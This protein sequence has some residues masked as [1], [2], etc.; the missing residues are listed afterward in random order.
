MFTLKMTSEESQK[1]A[2]HMFLLHQLGASYAF[3][4]KKFDVCPARVGQ[5]LRKRNRKSLINQEVRNRCDIER[6]QSWKIFKP[7]YL[8]CINNGITFDD[9]TA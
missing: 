1:R 7:I 2:E 9:S 5:I 6:E 4:G 8:W 3:I